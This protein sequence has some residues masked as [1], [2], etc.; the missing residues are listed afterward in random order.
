MIIGLTGRI[1]SG[2]GVISDFLKENGLEYLSLSQEVREEAKTRGIPIERKYLQDLG[3]QM[4]G[5]EGLEVLAKRA[6]KKI[7]TNKNYIIDAIRNTGEVYEL[8]RVFQ[9]N[10]YLIGVDADS[11]MRWRNMQNRGKESDPK[12]FEGFLEIDKRDFEE[13]EGNGQQVKKCMELANYH[14]LNNGTI[15][16]LKDK[17]KIIYQEIKK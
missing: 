8:K 17:I 12:T 15:E 3:N 4:R 2:K 13:N 5:E 9:N 6:I 11:E 14:I 7:D 10:F 1:A 16:D